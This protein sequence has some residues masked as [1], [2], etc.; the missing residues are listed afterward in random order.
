MPIYIITGR[1][2]SGKSLATVCR[3]R[4]LLAEGRPVATNLDLNLEKLCGPKAKT[5]RVVRLPDKPTVA[6]LDSLGRGNESYDETKNGGI[7]LDEVSQL[8]NARNWQDKR[9]QDVID[10]LVHSRKKG[11]DVYFICQHISQ[12]DR[13]VRDAL[14]EYLVECRRFDRLKIPFISS[15]VDTFTLGKVK[16]KLPRMH[17]AKVLYGTEF[18]AMVAD[19]WWYRGEDLYAAYDTRQVFREDASQAPYSYLP[20]WY[21]HGRLQP[22][23]VRGIEAKLNERRKILKLR[24]AGIITQEQWREW[25]NFIS[26]CPSW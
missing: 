11:W 2:G 19:R 14:V 7:F 12:V 13:Q 25:S 22:Q 16:L 18:N 4:D 8:L 15:A 20:G 3:I 1:L 5:P 23:K 10:W 21:T 24:E 6:H 17:V 26:R 9:Q